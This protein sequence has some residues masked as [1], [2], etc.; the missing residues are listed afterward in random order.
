MPYHYNLKMIN[1]QMYWVV[2]PAPPIADYEPIAAPTLIPQED[3]E[4]VINKFLIGCDPEFVMLDGSG[5][6]MNGAAY[7]PDNKEIGYDHGGRVCEFRPGPTKGVYPLLRKIKHFLADKRLEKASKLRAGAVC[8]PDTLGGH[9]HFGFN[10]YSVLPASKADD[11]TFTPVGLH[12]VRALDDLTKVLEH[13]DILPKEE[14]KVRRL[15][16]DEYGKFYG[17]F[18]NVRD[19][20]GHMEYRS[21]ASW[22]YDPKVAFLCLTA[23]KL[24]AADPTGA[25]EALKDC[26]SFA[27]LKAWV[28][29][30][31]TK[32]VNASRAS[33]KLLDSGLSHL[34]VD[35]TV[36]FRTRWETLGL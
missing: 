34:Q 26:T 27:G 22:L 10:C 15:K 5:H 25:H 31:K 29:N 21:M 28:E 3:E 7:F 9:V 12:V 2:E 30:Y 24:A 11:G 23:A 6:W 19:C 16:K 13:L 33:E 35:P 18:S 8:S 4:M 32:D 36:D 20:N 1:G 14:C 17:S